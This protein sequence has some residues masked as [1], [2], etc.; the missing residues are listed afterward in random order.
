MELYY[1]H[2]FAAVAKEGSIRKAVERLYITPPTASG[3]IKALEEEL[4]IVLF[5]RN[6]K[7]MVLT[8]EGQIL[9][10][11]AEK[12][13]ASIRRLQDKATE[14]RGNISGELLIGLNTSSKLLKAAELAVEV[15]R[16]PNINITFEPSS[17]GKI[18]DGL[19]TFASLSLPHSNT[20]RNH[21][22]GRSWLYCHGFAQTATVR[23]RQWPPIC[24]RSKD[25]H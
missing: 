6:P 23:S 13:I 15:Q 16:N 12:I 20:A 25:W 14:L 21:Q 24:L 17:T 3:H 8:A 7:G 11:Q 18:L 4:Q 5:E 22:T 9:L 19:S 10:E 2:T 1:L